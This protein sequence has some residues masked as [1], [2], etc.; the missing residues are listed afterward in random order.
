MPFKFLS[1]NLTRL[2]KRQRPIRFNV[3]QDQEQDPTDY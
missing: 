1:D 3:L 2:L